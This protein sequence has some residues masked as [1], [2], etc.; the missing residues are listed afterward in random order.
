[1]H[2]NARRV[3]EAAR[4]LG[5]DIA[6]REFPEGT[7]TAADAAAAIGVEL[8]QIVKSLVFSVDD[9][10]VIALVSGDNML[11]EARLADAAGGAHA[12]RV[13]AEQVRAATG[14][15]VG[16]V[17]PIGHATPLRVFVDE[18]LLRFD[19]VWAAAGTPHHNFAVAPGELVRVTGARVGRLARS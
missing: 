11:D 14:Y 4:N 19:E 3:I 12:S 5:I 1:M 2:R 13:D 10:L 8:G 7:R 18:D 16:G 9:E 15:P 6:P 17:P